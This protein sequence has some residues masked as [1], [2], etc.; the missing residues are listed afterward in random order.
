MFDPSAMAMMYQNMVKASS[1]GGMPANN[2][3]GGFDPNAMAMMYQNMMK[4]KSLK[5]NILT[6]GMGMGQAPAINPNMARGMGGG[7]GAMGGMGMGMGGMGN[8][9]GGMMGGNMMGGMGGMGG[10][11]GGNFGGNGNGG[12]AGGGGNGGGM[13]MGGGNGRVSLILRPPLTMQGRNVPNAPRG[14][15]AMRNTGGPSGMAQ[16]MAQGSSG[17][18]GSGSGSGSGPQRYSTQGSQRAKPY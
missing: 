3:G 1:G 15:A 9:M 17:N 4:G 11:A 5:P 10:M 18:G 16:P 7:M 12:G 2:A 6:K 14:P 8:M 13:G